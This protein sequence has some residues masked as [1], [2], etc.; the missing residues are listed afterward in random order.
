MLIGQPVHDSTRPHVSGVLIGYTR[1]GM[2][3]VRVGAKILYVRPENAKLGRKHRKPE[4]KE[5]LRIFKLAAANGLT[6][7]QARRAIA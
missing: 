2:C 6:L 3:Q 4:T 1:D 5:G 7:E